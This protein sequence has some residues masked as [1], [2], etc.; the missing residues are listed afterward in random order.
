M[1]TNTASKLHRCEETYFFFAFLG[2]DDFTMFIWLLWNWTAIQFQNQNK[3]KDAQ[4]KMINQKCWFLKYE[5]GIEVLGFV[6]MQR[7]RLDQ[8]A[9][10]VKTG[11]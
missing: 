3:S 10:F 7:C 9:D 8:D 11:M 1:E 2:T 4:P 6:K 5:P